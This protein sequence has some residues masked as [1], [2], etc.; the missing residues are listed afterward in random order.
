MFVFGGVFIYVCL[1]VNTSQKN[2]EELKWVF[3]EKKEMKF[4]EEFKWV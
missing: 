3:I 4:S 1:N 2:N